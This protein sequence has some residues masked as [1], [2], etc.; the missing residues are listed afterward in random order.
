[1][2]SHDRRVNEYPLAQSISQSTLDRE[3]ERLEAAKSL[4]FLRRIALYV[5]LGGPGF[6]GAAL[7]LGAG[8]MTAAMI[9]G[10]TWGYRTLWLSLIAIGS[11]VFMM[12]AMARFTCRGGFSLL[13]MQKKKHGVLMSTALAALIGVVAVAIVFNFGQYALATHLIESI[14]ELAGVTFPATMNWPL[15][16]AVTVWMTLSYG[17]GRKGTT[18]VER[19]MK[20]SLM[21]MV[22]CFAASL[23]VVGIDWSAA[24]KGLFIPWLPSG[25]R[26]IDLFIASSAAAIGVMDWVI[27]HYA[28]LTKGWGPRH[29]KLARIDILM[30]FALP[31]LIVNFLVV[32]VFAAT[33]YG[34]GSIPQSATELAAALM[35]LLGETLGKAVFLLGFLAIPIT[36]TVGMGIACGIAIHEAFGWRPDV[37]SWR[38]RIAVLLPQIAFLGAWLPNPIWLI[39]ILAATLSVTNNI[40]GWSFF[41]LFNDKSVL[42]ENRCK[43]YGWN[44]GILVQLTLLNCVAIAYVFN[45]M[46][47]WVS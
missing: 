43:S 36:T 7:T 46:G 20:Y 15:F 39:I 3:A 16:A 9:S 33:L 23:A 22:V 40:V 32:S 26:G 31:F 10:A 44:L 11:G 42:G 27:F 12:A 47:L 14:A 37:D 45:R 6:L 8:T 24:M 21:L 35:P 38:W 25:I 5:S 13:Q 28:G 17:R 2:S 41:L 29:E 4:P 19:F 1:M 30:G 34:T 18:L